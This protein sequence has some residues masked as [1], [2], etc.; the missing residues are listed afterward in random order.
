MQRQDVE[1]VST[2]V[3]ATP[4][5]TL[6]LRAAMASTLNAESP[7]FL[8][9]LAESTYSA[10]IIRRDRMFEPGVYIAQVVEL[11]TFVSGNVKNKT[12]GQTIFVG[13]FKIIKSNNPDVSPGQ[14]RAWL[15]NLSTNSFG[16]S[17]LKAFILALTGESEE[18]V[19]REDFSRAIS[20]FIGEQ[21]AEGL[22]IKIEAYR[23]PQKDPTDTRPGFLKYTFEHL[24]ISEF[25]K[26]IR[27]EIVSAKSRP[28]GK[29]ADEEDLPL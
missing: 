17:D 15:F 11:R 14:L 2:V 26:L 24:P 22:P 12:V 20:S 18:K 19:T 29:L 13:T 3:E 23:L 1:K 16:L 9:A 6:G 10:E 4:S 5:G 27:D 25:N 28:V 21:A 7:N 8:T